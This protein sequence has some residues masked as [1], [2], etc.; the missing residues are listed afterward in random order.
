MELRGK[1]VTEVSSRHRLSLAADDLSKGILDLVLVF[2]G[3]WSSAPAFLY[4]GW[5]VEGLTSPHNKEN[6][7]PRHSTHYCAENN[8]EA[9]LRPNVDVSNAFPCIQQ[10]VVYFFVVRGV[11]YHGPHQ[12]SQFHSPLHCLWNSPKHINSRDC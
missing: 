3:P 4:K 12:T 8:I 11:L 7:F 6:P 2:I 10:S 1:E 5:R 9:N